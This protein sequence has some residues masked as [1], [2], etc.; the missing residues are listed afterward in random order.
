MTI[1][2]QYF[3]FTVSGLFNRGNGEMI[4]KRKSQAAKITFELKQ[5]LRLF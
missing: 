2:I 3:K 5:I 4:F 1:K